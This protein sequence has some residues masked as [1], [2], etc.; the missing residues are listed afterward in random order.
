LHKI[1]YKDATRP[2]GDA[3]TNTEPEVNSHGVIGGRSE[4][5]F[6]VLSDIWIKFGPQLKKLFLFPVFFS[7]HAQ[8]HFSNKS[9][10]LETF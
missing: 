7:L 10:L 3:D 4:Q 5:M 2:C 9:F 6:V 1:W 8:T